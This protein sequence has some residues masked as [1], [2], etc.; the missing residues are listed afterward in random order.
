MCNQSCFDSGLQANAR[1][2][3]MGCLSVHSP[4]VV[5]LFELPRSPKNCFMFFNI[6]CAHEDFLQLV[7]TSWDEPIV[8]T[9]QFVC[10]GN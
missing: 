6:W 3:P 2:L 4:C 10:A 7:E 8:G 1:F 9:K 5:S